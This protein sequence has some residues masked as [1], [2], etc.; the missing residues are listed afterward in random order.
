M[1]TWPLGVRG[2]SLRLNTRRICR[3]QRRRLRRSA[4]GIFKQRQT[5]GCRSKPK[6]MHRHTRRKARVWYPW[7]RVEGGVVYGG[8]GSY[9]LYADYPGNTGYTGGWQQGTG[10]LPDVPMAPFE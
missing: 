6:H 9:S 7:K 5:G 4:S 10:A 3:R 8:A 2:T 1:S